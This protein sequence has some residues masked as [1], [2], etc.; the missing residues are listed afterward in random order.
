M[1][2]AQLN[3]TWERFPKRSKMEL[4]TKTARRLSTKRSTNL[5][6]ELRWNHITE[7]C[8]WVLQVICQ[9]SW[10]FLG[11]WSF[12]LQLNQQ[13]WWMH[14]GYIYMYIIH[15]YTCTHLDISTNKSLTNDIPYLCRIWL[16]TSFAQQPKSSKNSPWHCGVK[17]ST[18]DCKEQWR[19]TSDRASCLSAGWSS[20]ELRKQIWM[21]LVIFLEITR[22]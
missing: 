7:F 11:E 6:L 9:K 5:C 15:I 16:F 4:L 2:F 19:P 13:T 21:Q 18:A 1:F 17:K 22:W 3:V 10:Q 12:A 8:S 20:Q 14:V